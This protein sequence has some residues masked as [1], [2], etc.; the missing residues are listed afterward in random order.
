MPQAPTFATF[1]R[2]L[3]HSVLVPPSAAFERSLFSSPAYGLDESGQGAV[4]TVYFVDESFV[5]ASPPLWQSDGAATCVFAFP[6]STSGS[7]KADG[8]ATCEFAFVPLESFFLA[9]GTGGADF[10][11]FSDLA[12]GFRCDG[13]GTLDF[14]TSANSWRSD[15]AGGA[16]FQG[17][18]VPAPTGFKAQGS[19]GARFMGAVGTGE[20]C[21]TGTVPAMPR[22]PNFV[23]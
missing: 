21:L 6:A 16:T 19:G 3:V 8:S 1:E 10:V 4:A 2:T 20:D 23:Y 17:Q 11:G 7:F 5:S 13:A 15:G 14:Y 9:E 18:S 12:S 22:Q